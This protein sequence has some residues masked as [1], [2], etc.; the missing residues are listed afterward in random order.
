MA[1]A[2]AEMGRPV[3]RISHEVF[4]VLQGHS[5]PGNIRE[6][7]N[8]MERA[9][10]LCEDEVRHVHLPL[11]RMIHDS[12]MF[13]GA[14]RAREDG[15]PTLHQTRYDERQ[16]MKDALMAWGGNQTRAAESLGMPR[17]TFVSKLDRYGFPRPLENVV[18]RVDIQI[19]TMPVMSRAPERAG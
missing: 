13:V 7:K 1:H 9:A 12:G 2:C 14:N 11:D 6:L 3:P 15:A 18:R 8:Y 4:A 16:R 10:L 19:S 17:R 5:W